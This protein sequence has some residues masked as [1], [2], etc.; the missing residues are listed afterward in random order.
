MKLWIVGRWI[1]I[2]GA[3]LALPGSKGAAS[4]APTDNARLVHVPRLR[5]GTKEE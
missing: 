4:N 5:P 3:L 2:V 1:L